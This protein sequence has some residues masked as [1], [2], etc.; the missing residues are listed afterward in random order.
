MSSQNEYAPP[1]G[2][3]AVMGQDAAGPAAPGPAAPILL[4]GRVLAVEGDER[5]SLAIGEGQVWARRALSC[6]VAPEVG[7]RVLVAPADGEA[8]VLAVLDRLLPDAVS[9]SAPEARRLVI[10]APDV[11]IAAAGRLTLHGR[12]AAVDAE[13]VS[14]FSAS[15]SLVGRVATFITDLLRT[16]ARRTE[17]VSDEVALQAGTRTTRISGADVSEVGTLVRNVEQVSVETAHSAVVTAKEDLRFD[18]TRVTVG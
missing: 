7:D 15:F 16:T 4:C 5:L 8:F 9:L 11:S 2:A 1:A 13:K 10:A 6:L 17:T 14:I 12:E 18:G 3:V